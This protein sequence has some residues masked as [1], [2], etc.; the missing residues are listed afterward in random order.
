MNIKAKP[1][2]L[3]LSLK[4]YDD[5]VKMNSKDDNTATV[6]QQQRDSRATPNKSDK[7]VKSEKEHKETIHDFSSEPDTGNPSHTMQGQGGLQTGTSGAS[8]LPMEILEEF[9]SLTGK[10]FRMTPEKRKQITERLKTFTREDIV[11]AIKNRLS[12]PS[13][14]GRNKTG[15]VWAHDWNSLFRNNENMDR[16][17]QLQVLK[18]DKF[19]EREMEELDFLKFKDKYGKELALKYYISN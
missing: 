4:F 2:G 10:K 15:T 17:F 8:E 3:I 14:M 9:N 11:Q 18:D 7:T 16:A 5:L 12:D 1:Y 19:Y 13:C 6:E